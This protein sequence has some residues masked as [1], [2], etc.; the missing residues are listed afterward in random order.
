MRRVRRTVQEKLHN[1]RGASLLYAFLFLLVASMVSTV[2]L[3]GAVTAIKRA[4]DDTTRTQSYL[5]LE[6][7]A[8]IFREE[9]KTSSVTITSSGGAWQY[10]HKGLFGEAIETFVRKA[11]EGETEKVERR[12]VLTVPSQEEAFQAVQMD[13]TLEQDAEI[14]RYYANGVIQIQSEI[15]SE[16]KGTNQKLYLSGE[17][18]LSLPVSEEKQTTV[19]MDSTKLHT[20]PEKQEEAAS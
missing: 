4:H 8:G 1:R 7:A 11:V 5:T 10:A 20:R 14:E 6:S 16:G 18:N 3:S 12:F 2:I 15:P 9:L 13:F 17:L 19:S